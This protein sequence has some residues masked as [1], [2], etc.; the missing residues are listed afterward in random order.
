MKKIFSAFLF[1]MMFLISSS[2]MAAAFQETVPKDSE[3]SS[4]KRLAVAFPR[5]YKTMDTE[6]TEEELASIIF[7]ASRVARC[8]VIS[9]D[10]IAANIKNELHIKLDELNDAEARKIFEQNVGKYADAFVTVT[11]ATNSKKVQFFFDV[12][13]VDSGN[14]VYSL[15]S[16]SGDWSRDLKGYTKACE[17]F[18]K[19]FDAAAE[20]KIK[21]EEKKSRQKK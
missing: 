2:A 1:A 19:K 8:Y 18:Y 10:E 5:H 13:K 21:E 12:Q 17:D 4:V 9:Y 15:T 14:L 6:P 20:K 16:Q 11:T 7:N 3:I